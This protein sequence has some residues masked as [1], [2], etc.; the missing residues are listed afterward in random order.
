MLKSLQ[1]KKIIISIIFGLLGFW[2]NFHSV[3]FMQ[4]QDF[5]VSV[6]MGLLFPLMIAIFWGWKYGL[7]SALFGGCQSMWWLWYSD[8]YGILYAVPIFTLWIVWH[9]YWADFRKHHEYRWYYSIY[10]VE[11]GFR[12]FSEFGFYTV[13][14]WLVA[15]NPPPWAPDITNNIVPISW[16]NFVA[17]KHIITAYILL[18]FCDVLRHIGPIRK[19]FLPNEKQDRGKTSWIIGGAILVGLL[20][21]LFHTIL[22]CF[23]FHRGTDTFL[24]L[25]SV[26]IPTDSLIIRNL[27]LFSSLIV[28]VILSRLYLKYIT[29][30]A[31]IRKS[32]KLYRTVIVTTL[33][34][35]IR[36]GPDNIIQDVNP[37][38][39]NLLEFSREEII[40]HYL[41]EFI[42]IEQKD[43]LKQK[44]ELIESSLHQS[45]EIDLLTKTGKIINALINSTALQDSDKNI[46]GVCAFIKD[47]SEL[48]KTEKKL[49][50]YQD[51]L[52]ELVK[53]RT[54]E[55]EEKTKKL[56][57]SQHS[58]EL[59]LEDVN[60]A[61]NELDLSNQKLQDSNKELQDFAYSV[62]H[63]LRAP[64]RS[65][66]G[67]SE[68]VERRY[69]TL[70]PDEAQQYF[71]FI[72]EAGNNMADLISDLLR[73]SRLVQ[74]EKKE[75][76]LKR[77]F[78]DVVLNLKQDLN[79]SH[80]KLLLP[81][82]LPV[83]ISNAVMVNQIF[84]NLILNAIT[85]QKQGNV[86][87]IVIE[88]EVEKN[89][90]VISVQDNGIGI[91]E[92]YHEKV[93]AIFQR[94]HSA[95]E[96]VGTGIGLAIV[97]KA[98]IALGGKIWLVS[99]VGKGTTFYIEL[100]VN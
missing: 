2:I 76:D 96:Y 15:L 81:E 1:Y 56:E 54:E 94:L 19:F 5:Q 16:V 73:Y 22:D 55:L 80:A 13:F 46:T 32:D 7:L 50:D 3:R 70:L 91:D 77:I 58:L 69:K 83:I 82:K 92:K 34:G 98:V 17:I 88:T 86:P 74:K 35:Y 62:S 78:D 66:I 20:F 93:F 12:I 47:I 84:H 25:L 79:N 63:D 51:H 26:N 100:P 99:E 4:F 45:Y 60:K 41:D 68:I 29:K 85:Y 75:V 95:K 57:K 52:E 10:V 24:N 31:E 48:K 44:L 89:K 30:D 40:G 61:K 11:I 27:F 97:K 65:I 28:G 23:I 33:E 71:S 59:L 8:G 36:L 64:L 38:L 37:S 72:I 43:F 87:E 49:I 39:C 6:L 18:L 42:K 21:W 67:F 53:E 9:G 90:I 14:R